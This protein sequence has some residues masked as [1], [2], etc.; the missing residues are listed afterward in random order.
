MENQHKEY[1]QAMQY[2]TQ[3]LFRAGI[4]LGLAPISVLPAQSQQHFKEAGHEF[5]CGLAELTHGFAH[6]LDKMVK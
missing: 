2:F 6:T 4:G 1:R 3:S 5:I